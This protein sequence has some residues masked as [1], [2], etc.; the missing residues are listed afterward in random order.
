M[1]EIEETFSQYFPQQRPSHVNE[2]PLIMDTNIQVRHMKANYK[3][4]NFSNFEQLESN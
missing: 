1:L 2:Y 3:L 4:G